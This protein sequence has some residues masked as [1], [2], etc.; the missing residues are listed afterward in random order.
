MAT[1]RP[2]KPIISSSVGDAAGKILIDAH[3]AGYDLEE[4]APDRKEKFRGERKFKQE[5]LD[6]LVDLSSKGAPIAGQS[7]TNDPDQPHPWEKPAEFSNPR[8]ALDEIVNGI[9]QPEA[10]K[11]IVGALAHGAAVADLSIAILYAKFS[12]GAVN[13]DVMLLLVEPVMFI[14]MAIGEEAEIKYNIEGN[15][16]DELDEDDSNESGEFKNKLNSFQ[17]AFT[18]IKNTAVKDK[19]ITT[20]ISK[21]SVPPSILERVKEQVE[22]QKPEIESILSRREG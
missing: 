8:E 21:G 17:N 20:N 13:P 14:I 7:L 5:S 12:E 18:D 4:F 22:E 19:N 10:M 3:E 16:L 11:H 15:D 9:L 1:P 6:E 2:L